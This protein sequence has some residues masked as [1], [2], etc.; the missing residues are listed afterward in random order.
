MGVKHAAMRNKI[1][2]ICCIMAAKDYI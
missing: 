2:N 1:H